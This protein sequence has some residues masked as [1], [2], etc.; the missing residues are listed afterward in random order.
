MVITDEA[1]SGAITRFVAAPTNIRIGAAGGAACSIPRKVVVGA[2]VIV[3]AT[4]WAIAVTLF[5]RLDDTV[6]THWVAVGVC[7]GVTAGCTALISIN[8][9]GN[10]CIR[11]MSGAFV[12]R[13]N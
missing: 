12:C 3:V 9:L 10:F 13:S 7:I 6:A 11:A 5:S 8:T 2:D 1:T 4:G